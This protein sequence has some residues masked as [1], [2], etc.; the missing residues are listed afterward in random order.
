MN[1]LIIFVMYGGV[2]ELILRCWERHS[3][4]RIKFELNENAKLIQNV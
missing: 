3:S 4:N 1:Y 2:D